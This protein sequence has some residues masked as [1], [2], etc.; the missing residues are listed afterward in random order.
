MGP[1]PLYGG[2]LEPNKQFT[3]YQVEHSSKEVFRL[4]RKL[5]ST[6]FDED[7]DLAT[8]ALIVYI[9]GEA[10]PSILKDLTKLQNALESIAQEVCWVIA[11]STD[12]VKT[13]KPKEYN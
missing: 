1:F 7:P 3:T 10:D 11:G 6:L 4:V 13:F 12:H 8:T 2:I 5:Q 9:L